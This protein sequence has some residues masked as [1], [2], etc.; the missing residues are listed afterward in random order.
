MNKLSETFNVKV[1]EK[2]PQCGRRAVVMRPRVQIPGYA[3]CYELILCCDRCNWLELVKDKRICPECESWPIERFSRRIV[4]PRELN[5][6]DDDMF[7]YCSE[8]GWSE[9][10]E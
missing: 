7:W 10:A 2:C 9:L 6:S 4:R 5:G 1:E 8:C 3:E